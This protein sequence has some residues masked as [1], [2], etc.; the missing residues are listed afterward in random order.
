MNI[1]YNK[2][3]TLAKE[4]I[5]EK[6]GFSFDLNKSNKSESLY[7]F[8]HYENMMK[9]IR[10]S[11]HK[12]VYDYSFDKEIVSDTINAECLKRAIKNVCEHLKKKRLNYCFRLLAM[13][14]TQQA[15]C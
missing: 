9:S 14:S 8:I 3:E 6:H 1:D 5:N 7:L 10:I 2:V 13:Q 4:V 12:N 11:N 15:Y